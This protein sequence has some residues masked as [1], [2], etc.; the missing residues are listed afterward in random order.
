MKLKACSELVAAWAAQRPGKWNGLAEA[1][2]G[3]DAAFGGANWAALVAADPTEYG[4][5]LAASARSSRP[6]GP[7]AEA[8]GL[9]S[10]KGDAA[11]SGEIS[12]RLRWDGRA[13]VLRDARFYEAQ[14]GSRVRFALVSPGVIP[15]VFEQRS[16]SYS[17]VTFASPAL[18]DHFRIL[19]C[20]CP[21]S[22]FESEWRKNA[23]AD[24]W[25]LRLRD[26][27][28]WPRFLRLDAA[29][30][31]GSEAAA[32]SLVLAGRGV[33]ALS[34]EGKSLWAELA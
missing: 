26:P 1:L 3:A 19:N 32:M 5:G 7:V 2:A 27:E 29:I 13:G 28:P 23:P 15:A 11:G 33:R 14:R 34:W 10:L 8:L 17:T 18:R 31:F 12:L 25:R 4:F 9:K 16:A 22:A 21:I 6:L 20:R 30:P 24:S